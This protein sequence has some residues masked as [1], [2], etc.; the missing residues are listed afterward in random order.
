MEPSVALLA[1]RYVCSVPSSRACQRVLTLGVA[2]CGAQYVVPYK[3]KNLSGA[4][5]CAQADRW[6]AYGTIEPSAGEAIKRVANNPDQFLDL[7]RFIGVIRA[8]SPCSCKC[9]AA[10]A[11]AATGGGVEL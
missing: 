6:V 10:A 3:G 9:G 2:W 11:A 4:E 5:L 7:V 8:A 1:R